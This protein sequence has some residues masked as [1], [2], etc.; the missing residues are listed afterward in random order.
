MGKIIWNHSRRPS[1]APLKT[2][3]GNASMATNVK[4]H[5]MIEIYRFVIDSAFLSRV[6]AMQEVPL[7]GVGRRMPPSLDI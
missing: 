2:A 7:S 6:H 4:I 5:K 1:L 3:F